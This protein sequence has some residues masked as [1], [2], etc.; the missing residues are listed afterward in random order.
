[1][2]KI[3]TLRSLTEATQDHVEISIDLQLQLKQLT[4]LLFLLAVQPFLHLLQV[5]VLPLEQLLYFS[6]L[7]FCCQQSSFSCSIRTNHWDEY[8]LMSSSTVSTGMGPF[9]WCTSLWELV[10]A[11]QS[12]N[13]RKEP[14]KVSNSTHLRWSSLFILGQLRLLYQDSSRLPASVLAWRRTSAASCLQGRLHYPLLETERL[15]PDPETS[16]PSLIAALV[17]LFVREQVPKARTG[18]SPSVIDGASDTSVWLSIHVQPVHF[19]IQRLRCLWRTLT[20]QPPPWKTWQNYKNELFAF[21][22]SLET[23]ILS[24]SLQLTAH[25]HTPVAH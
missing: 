3:I 12:N 15:P 14:Q 21:L 7:R 22:I 8:M 11:L 20:L 25:M 2:E 4:L 16:K 9:V 10:A 19:R 6:I 18:A 1:M 5:K 13:G 17:L 24:L 23:L